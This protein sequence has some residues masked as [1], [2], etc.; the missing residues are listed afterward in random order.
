MSYLHCHNCDWGQDDFWE[1]SWKGVLV[2]WKFWKWGYRPLGYNPL[3]MILEDIH[4]YGKPRYVEFDKWYA[5][6]REW[7]S[8][9]VHSWFLLKENI[10][11]QIRKLFF[12]KW[13]TW[14]SWKKD[15]ENKRARCPGCGSSGHFDID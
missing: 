3:S 15:Y 8:N 13:W 5:E 12:Q 1:W 10:K 9:K 6:E 7:K 11:R 4:E 14:A 2:L